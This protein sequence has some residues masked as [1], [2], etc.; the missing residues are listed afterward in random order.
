MNCAESFRWR[1]FQAEVILLNVRWYCRY[2]L[3][4]RDLKEMMLER[5]LEVDHSSIHRWVLSY[6]PE[7]DQRIRPHLKPTNDSWKVDETYIKIRG[8]WKYLYRAIDSDGYTLDFLLTARRNAAA[9]ER[10]LRKLLLNDHTQ[11]PRVIN[12]DKNPAYPPAF[13]QLQ[14]D[15]YLPDGSKLRAVKY[16]N[17]LLEQDHRP[18]KRLVE[19][20]MGFGSIY[21]ARRTLKGYESM[22]MLRKGQVKG[23]EKGNVMGQISF[24]HQIFG[25][26]A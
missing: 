18:I 12:V 5:G 8:K 16:L 1:H 9:A 24:I 6:G 13:D 26:A 11:T 2:S 15:G 21:T 7:L 17:N 20:G 4:Y 14:E 23:V 3:S 25:V 22:K 10:F 19:P